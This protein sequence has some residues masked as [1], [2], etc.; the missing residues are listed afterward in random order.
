MLRYIAAQAITAIYFI[1]NIAIWAIFYYK[2]I[3]ISAPEDQ[4][5]A[6][7]FQFQFTVSFWLFWC[8]P[9]VLACPILLFRPKISF[10]AIIVAPA[11][12]SL[13]IYMTYFSDYKFAIEII[14]AC[15]FPSVTFGVVFAIAN[16]FSIFI[17]KR[18]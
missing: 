11:V 2:S 6:A 4:A 13:A 5:V 12:N 17:H 16:I 7:F 14:N 1:A 8:L 10:L 15:F 18:P 3:V 9:G